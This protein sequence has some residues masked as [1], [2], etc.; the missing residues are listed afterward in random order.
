VKIT[1]ITT[2][3]QP[4]RR[5]EANKETICHDGITR[6]NSKANTL[7]LEKK[8]GVKAIIKSSNTDV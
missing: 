2:Q 1:I 7:K 4:Q 8:S 5:N 3:Q 6:I